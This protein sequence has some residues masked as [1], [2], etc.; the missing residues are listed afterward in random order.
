MPNKMTKTLPILAV[1][2]ALSAALPAAAAGPANDAEALRADLLAY[3]ENLHQLPV[4]LLESVYGGRL[5]L[6]E[7]RQGILE[8]SPEEL[9]GMEPTLEQVPYWRELPSLLAVSLPS[10]EHFGPLELA[11]TLSA[12]MPAA[13]GIGLR[14]EMLRM[15]DSL[16]TVPS[17][18]VGNDY[19]ARTARLRSRL[20]SL[21]PEE[22]I[23]LR[24]AMNTRMP[25][26]RSAIEARLAGEEPPAGLALRTQ[27][28]CQDAAFPNDILC[29]IDHIIAEIAAIP[30]EV[31]AFAE[32]AFATVTGFLTD[33]LAFF[34]EDLIPTEA[35]ILGGIEAALGVDLQDPQWMVDF[36]G[37]FPKLQPPC[38]P[39]G[40]SIPGLGEMGTTEANLTCKR[41]IKW[42]AQAIYDNAPD[43]IWGVPFKLIMAAVFYPIDYL[44]LCY[45]AAAEIRYDDLQ[46]AHR[47]LVSENL[48]VTVSSRATQ[49]SVDTAQATTTDLHG[50][51]GGVQGQVNTLNASLLDLDQDVAQVEAKLDILGPKVDNVQDQEDEQSLFLLDFQELALRLR[52]EA[53]LVRSGSDRVSSF[54]LPEAVGGFL[55]VVQQIV[56]DTIE[57]RFEGGRNVD[58]AR[59]SFARGNEAYAALDFKRAYDLYRKAYS[60]AVQGNV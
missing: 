14:A 36:F 35:E 12:Q 45:E 17:G 48:D 10:E 25:V 4:S 57:Q 7:A 42:V 32:D 43:D 41:S 30:D 5:S 20:E 21:S 44:C 52:I 27:A 8:M 53:D 18:A 3:V 23:A 11:A 50:D 19:H 39:N 13:G 31:V 58:L 59:S 24:Q 40:F 46:A 15:V 6:A 47:D 54:Q 28:N 9:R 2:V 37:S 34:D 56:F 29:E 26:W 16:D 33:L 38:P 55:E 22:A 60:E 49:V 1:M 51:L